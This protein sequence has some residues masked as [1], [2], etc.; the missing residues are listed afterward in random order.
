MTQGSGQQKGLETLKLINAAST[1]L[2]L[3]PGGSTQVTEAFESAYQGVKLFVRKNRMLRFSL[4]NGSYWLNGEPADNPT[5][6]RLELLSFSDQLRKLEFNELVFYKGIDR[7]RFKKILS[8]LSATPDQVQAAGGSWEFVE[9][10]GLGD[11]F[12]KEY[13]S[14]GEIE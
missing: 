11:V 1:A 10:L 8:V 12:P 3:Y 14:P 4:L 6:E 2:R 5:R 9:Q 13:S 7:A